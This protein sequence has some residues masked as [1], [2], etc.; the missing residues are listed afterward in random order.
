M[1]VDWRRETSGESGEV[2][3]LNTETLY[4]K[5]CVRGKGTYSPKNKQKKKNSKA[6][7]SDFKSTR[8]LHNEEIVRKGNASLILSLD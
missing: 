8:Q 7:H 6:T 2:T 1:T 3:C 4:E 5:L